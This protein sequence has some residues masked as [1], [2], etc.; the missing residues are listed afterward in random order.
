MQQLLSLQK[1]IEPLLQ[2]H[3]WLQQLPALMAFAQHLAF[4]LK[5]PLALTGETSLPFLQLQKS[6]LS[7]WQQTDDGRCWRCR[8]VVRDQVSHR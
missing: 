6:C 1:L 8:S 2:Q 3:L 4:P 5:P 7:R